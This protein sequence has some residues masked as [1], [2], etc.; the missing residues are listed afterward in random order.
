MPES[1]TDLE[2]QVI[3]AIQGDMP[4]VERPYE[5]MAAQLNIAEDRLL[6]ILNSVD[7]QR[8]YPPLRRHLAPPAIGL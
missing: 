2:K 1:L 3:A 4:I 7:R 8:H 6:D 5:Q